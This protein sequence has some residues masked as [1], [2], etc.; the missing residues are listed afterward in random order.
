LEKSRIL[1]LHSSADLYGSDRC[2]INLLTYLDRGRFEPHVIIPC[3]GP[4]IQAL[5]ELGIEPR[6]MSFGI[7]RRQ[8]FH[9]FGILSYL[10]SFFSG[11]LRLLFYAKRNRIA[12]IHTN[13][14]VI[15]TG[16]IVSK[17]LG[18]PHV[19]H[20][21]EIV[22]EP[23]WLRT[24]LS[25]L[26][27]L[28]SDK[29]I[30]M[31]EA[32]KDHFLETSWYRKPEKIGVVYDGID[33]DRFSPHVSGSRFRHE[34]G[35]SDRHVLVGMI[36]RINRWKGQDY[37]LE[38]AEEVLRLAPGIVFAM[39]GDAYR[40]EECL[41][42]DLK[43]RIASKKLDGKVRLIGFRKET[44]EI[45]SAFDIY[46]HPSILPEPF[47]LVVAEA[48]A[49]G[50]PVVANNLGGVREMVVH[51]QTGFLVD[52]KDKSQMAEAILQLIKD[53][54]LIEAMGQA[55][56]KRVIERFSVDQF[57]KRMDHLWCTYSPR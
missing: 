42:E 7:L 50:K 49:A 25:S 31:S 57:R 32:I 43:N 48:M 23:K 52:P 41:M 16:A 20:L 12:I 28:L 37:F 2:L 54:A 55:G 11:C 36:G 13:T 5:H 21:R 26:V 46:V 45:H 34:I 56:R 17:L 39:V 33:T 19:W 51:G 8:L 3:H 44:P 38:V 30:A 18:I 14:A 29:S 35:V 40:G 27:F 22:T 4:L 10:I 9:P 6:V 53:K 1:F 47:G 24:V 15:L